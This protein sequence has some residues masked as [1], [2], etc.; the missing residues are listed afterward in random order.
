MV[1]PS[2]VNGTFV[3]YGPP[4][5]TPALT[6]VPKNKKA[7]SAATTTSATQMTKIIGSRFFI[8]SLAIELIHG[9]SQD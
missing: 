4:F 2:S 8:K 6:M 9:Q 3:M 1:A 5:S 7:A